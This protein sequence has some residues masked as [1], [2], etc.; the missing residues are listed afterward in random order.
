MGPRR[1][2]FLLD[3]RAVPSYATLWTTPMRR[4]PPPLSLRILACS[5]VS[6]A[7][8]TRAVTIDNEVPAGTLGH[9]AVDVDTGGQTRNAT[10]TAERLQAKDLHTTDVVFEY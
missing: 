10:L 3:A 9:W 8:A 2:P 5:L 6:P 4:F 7:P 1:V